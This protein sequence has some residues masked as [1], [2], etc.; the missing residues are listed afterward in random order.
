M[1]SVSTHI[2]FQNGDAQA[3]L[4]LYS[5]VFSDF[6]IASI[7]KNGPEDAAPGTVGIAMVD[8]KGHAL[9]VVDSPVPHNFNFTPSVS[10]F[11]IIDD[12]AELDDAFI[13]LVDG[14]EIKMPLDNYGFSP[15]FGWLTDRF[16]VS[17]QLSAPLN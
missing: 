11:V 3:A 10:L 7:K 5:S 15:R 16:G 17:W 14:G 12:T 2:M 9:I 6:K 4:D 13:K 1:T 8:F